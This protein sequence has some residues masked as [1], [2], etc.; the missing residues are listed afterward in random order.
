M[1]EEVFKKAE[2]LFVGGLGKVNRVNWPTW[3]RRVIRRS[4]ISFATNY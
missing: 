3:L 4:Y 2:I 1:I